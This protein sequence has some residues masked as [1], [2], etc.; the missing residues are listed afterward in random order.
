[1]KA[2]LGEPKS[3]VPT[4]REEALSPNGWWLRGVVGAGQD[5]ITVLGAAFPQT[6]HGRAAEER[7]EASEFTEFDGHVPGAGPALD[8]SP[9]TNVYA[10]TEREKAAECAFRF[11]LKRG[12]GVVP[13]G[14]RQRDKDILLALL[15][16][17]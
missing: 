13:A 1:M 9:L 12:L 15:T 4:D 16:R 7:R 10:V 17:V 3:A 6:A 8:P 2:A 11:F 14:E 5:G